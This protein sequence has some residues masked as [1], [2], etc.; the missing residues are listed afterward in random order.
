MKH[1]HKKKDKKRKQQRKEEELI[2]AESENKRARVDTAPY[3]LL[4]QQSGHEMSTKC[5]TCLACGEKGHVRKD[6]DAPKVVKS[7]GENIE[8][9]GYGKENRSSDKVEVNNDELKHEEDAEGNG[10]SINKREEDDSERKR[11][12]DDGQEENGTTR[13]SN[14]SSDAPR[15]SNSSPPNDLHNQIEILHRQVADCVKKRL[16]MYMVGQAGTEPKNI[17]IKDSDEYTR[18]AKFFSHKLR[19]QIKESY[20]QYNRTLEGVTITAD[21]KEQIKVEIDMYFDTQPVVV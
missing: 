3:C 11:E 15:V 5:A 10:I 16:D 13:E 18:L 9:N 14:P 2:E 21:N 7:E 6:C 8:L 19:A 12:S 1:K 17:K 20:E 4:C